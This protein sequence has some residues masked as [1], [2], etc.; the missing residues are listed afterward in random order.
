MEPMKG[1]CLATQQSLKR[2]FP[3][4]RVADLCPVCEI[5]IGF[6]VSELTTGNRSTGVASYYKQTIMFN[7]SK[8]ISGIRKAVFSCAS[9]NNG[10]SARQDRTSIEYEG[11]DLLCSVIFK[12][13]NDCRRFRSDVERMR[14]AKNIS[15]SNFQ[16]N[17]IEKCEVVDENS[18]IIIE[19]SSYD[20]EATS[21]NEIETIYSSSY[22]SVTTLTKNPLARLQMIENP[23]F[24][25]LSGVDL[26]RC[27]LI[28][29]EECLADERLLPFDKDE[30]NCLYMSWVLHQRFDGLY[31]GIPKI[32]IRFGAFVGVENGDICGHAYSRHKVSIVIEFRRNDTQEAQAIKVALGDHSYDTALNEFTLHVLVPDSEIF[33]MCLT[34]KY[35][36][37]I[38]IWD[39]GLNFNQQKAYRKKKRL[40]NDENDV[41]DD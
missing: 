8:R 37:N 36:A 14:S 16:K 33:S 27:H 21:S 13:L 20:A 25:L 17:V 29:R 11:E 7:N 12:D 40:N 4:L 5:K 41:N 24:K 19:D 1:A 26:V 28:S 3:D 38:A 31:D 32:A 30:N 23:D 35:V 18:L 39:G 15:D 6:H 9:F 34:R 2:D 10:F 22:E